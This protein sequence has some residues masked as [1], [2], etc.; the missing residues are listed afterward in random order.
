MFGVCAQSPLLHCFQWF[1]QFFFE[2]FVAN[3]R[4]NTKS[5]DAHARTRL[6]ADLSS[7]H[8][9][10]LVGNGGDR[11]DVA[12]EFALSAVVFV[13]FVLKSEFTHEREDTEGGARDP[14]AFVGSRAP[15]GSPSSSKFLSTRTSHRLWGSVCAQHRS[16]NKRA[17]RHE[18]S[19]T[20]AYSSCANVLTM[21][22]LIWLTL[23]SHLWEKCRT[24]PS[25]AAVTHTC[26]AQI[27]GTHTHTYTHI[28]QTHG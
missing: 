16:V 21:S 20:R 15:A 1:D 10:D 26:D 18:L 13:Q 9:S 17:Q 22:A 23:S 27:Q 11:H 6:S 14:P 28:T 4:T 24:N 12:S 5:F 7:S 8:V 2:N 25:T 3:V 19:Q